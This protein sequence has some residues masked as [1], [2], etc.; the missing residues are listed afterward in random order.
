M[1]EVSIGLNVVAIMALTISV[2]NKDKFNVSTSLMHCSIP[3]ELIDRNFFTNVFDFFKSDFKDA[4][5]D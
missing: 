4:F 3:S 2:I 5:F 1:L